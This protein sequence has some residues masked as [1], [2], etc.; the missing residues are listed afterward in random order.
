VKRTGT[1]V[2]LERWCNRG[3]S[4]IRT[5]RSLC[6]HRDP[7]IP[8]NF[9]VAISTSLPRPLPFGLPLLP[10]LEIFC[11]A[12]G[13]FSSSPP[14]SDTPTSTPL[15]QKSISLLLQST[16]TQNPDNM[17]ASKSQ[18]TFLF[19]SE[20]VGEGHP[21]KIAYVSSVSTFIPLVLPRSG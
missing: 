11:V 18:G 6:F 3:Y 16:Y 7:C 9:S 2:L 15:L 5:F 1:R 8:Q 13:S 19:T 17:T 12:C 4:T 21:D 10:P 20:S 14:P